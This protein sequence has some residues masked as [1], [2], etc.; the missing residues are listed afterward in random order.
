MQYLWESRFA[1][2][3]WCLR[4]HLLADTA[5]PPVRCHARTVEPSSSHVCDMDTLFGTMTVAMALAM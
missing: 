2:R 4:R 5:T 1:P 3:G